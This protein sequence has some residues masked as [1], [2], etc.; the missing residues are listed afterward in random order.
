MTLPAPNSS[1]PVRRVMLIST[2]PDLAAHRERVHEAL[3]RVDGLLP[4]PPEP[5]P[6]ARDDTDPITYAARR[7]ADICVL[8]VAWRYGHVPTGELRSITHDAYL[9]ARA[10][11]LPILVFLADPATDAPAGPNTPFPAV[12]RDPA[13]RAQLL[14]FRAELEFAHAVHYFSGPSDLAASVA[15]AASALLADLRADQRRQPALVYSHGPR[16]PR[17]LPPRAPGFVGRE[18][19]RAALLD[20]L[21]RG[22]SVGL[23]AVVAGTAGVGASSLAAEALHALAGE[24][25]A[26][27]GGIAWI[28]CDGR[29][30]L[31]GLAWIYDRVLAAWGAALADTDPPSDAPTGAPPPRTAVELRERALRQLRSSPSPSAGGQED[32]GDQQHGA[33]ALLPALLLLDNVERRL[34]LDR[35]LET[36]VPLAITVLVTARHRPA[37]PHLRLLP[38]DVLDTAAAI[39]LFASRYRDHGGSWETDPDTVGARFVIELLG[40][41]PLAIELAAARAAVFRLS[42]HAL[43]DELAAADRQG[44]LTG[45]LDTAP[46]VRYLLDQTLAGLPGARRARFAALALPDGSDW[47]LTIVERLLAGIAPNAP[48]LTSARADLEALATLSLITISTSHSHV[49]RSSGAVAVPR[50]SLHPLLRDRALAEWESQPDDIRRAA[51]IALLDALDSFIAPHRADPTALAR[52]EELSRGALR[53]AARYVEAELLAATAARWADRSRA[54]AVVP[55]G[56]DVGA[57]AALL[58]GDEISAIATAR[59]DSPA[60]PAAAPDVPPPTMPASAALPDLA[61][62]SLPGRISASIRRKRRWW[63]FGRKG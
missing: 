45:P 50:V 46:A 52:E 56:A 37:S 22:Q 58:T 12:T 26:F 34:P 20:T 32:R 6:P 39:R 23:S 62:S 51:A 13:H 35:A 59:L 11:G 9:E 29:T 18:R 2:S 61:P 44:W 57:P 16:T 5:V 10:A 47:P 38:L 7:R 17:D 60:T 3:A 21:R 42:V 36:L 28:R 1:S 25:D 24:P 19:E 40:R 48:G 53:A 15:S 43:G 49:A 14:A 55:P 27:P 41:L 4:L 63:P 31:D 8:L 30:E 33:Q 54:S